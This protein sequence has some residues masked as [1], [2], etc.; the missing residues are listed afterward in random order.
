MALNKYLE[1]NGITI[2]NKQKKR[3]L[4]EFFSRRFISPTKTLTT[5]S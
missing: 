4:Y 2:Q 5:M 1:I 3:I